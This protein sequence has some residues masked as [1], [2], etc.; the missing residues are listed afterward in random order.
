[1]FFQT[2]NILTYTNTLM[3][4]IFEEIA[5]FFLKGEVYIYIYLEF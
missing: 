5:R 4:I 3:D 1:M 2:I